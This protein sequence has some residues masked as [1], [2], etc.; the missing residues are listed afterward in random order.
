MKDPPK[1]PQSDRKLWLIMV[2]FIILALAL[3]W[4]N[5]S[6]TIQV[7]V[8]KGG[9]VLDF[10]DEGRFAIDQASARGFAQ[11][12]IK[13]APLL[14]A[15]DY[16]FL[17]A[18]SLTESESTSWQ[19]KGCETG[20]CSLAT[21]YDYTD[22]GTL[23]IVINMSSGEVI[24]FW[25]NPD[26][27]P[28][29]SP[30][31]LP[32][33]ISIAA[34][35]NEVRSVLGD[36]RQVESMMAPMST[37]LDDN[38]CSENWCVDLTFKS[39]DGSGKIFHVV[40]DLELGIVARTFYTRGRPER[41]HQEISQRE[42]NFEDGCHEEYE[43]EICWEMTAHDG[44]NF[45]DASY[46]G[47][48]IFTSAKIGQVEVF[49]PSW[50]GGYRDEI[51][52]G[53]SVRPY[54][55][56]QVDDLEEGFEV[57][58]LF[59]EFLSWPNCICCYRY[60]QKMRFFADGSFEA[61]FV[62]HGP[63][64]DD[65]SIYRPFWRINLAGESAESGAINFWD[66]REWLEAEKELELPLFERLG[67]GGEILY[68]FRQEGGYRW[69]P[70]LT[71][72]SGQDG[73]RIFVLAYNET[74]GD[75][76]ISTGPAN[77]LWPP[78]QW[79]DGEPLLTDNPVLWYIPSLNTH[80]GEPW[81]CMPDPEPDYSPCN[82]V[83]RAE[84]MVQ[85]KNAASTP[86]PPSEP[87]P[88]ATPSVKAGSPMS[89][90]LEPTAR[91]ALRRTPRPIAG[92]DAGSIILNSGCGSC[93]VIGSLGEI[94]KVGP[95]L[96]NIGIE[97]GN[98]VPGQSAEEFIRESILNP[99]AVIAADCPNGP[100]LDNIMPADYR[101]RL[102]GLQSQALVDFLLIQQRDPVSSEVTP[103]SSNQA[104]LVEEK[105]ATPEEPA[106]GVGSKLIATSITIGL[107]AL[108]LFLSL[109]IIALLLLLIFG[110]KDSSEKG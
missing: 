42:P 1:A 55:G 100:C 21:Y 50:P 58:Q 62:S 101:K 27:R 38:S 98:R 79:L 97:A 53:A 106:V 43:W 28:G 63:G 36:I 39:P 25:R 37:W 68:T 52:Q 82:A 75:G 90:A 104:S 6:R 60:E 95:D 110:A 31:S 85:V 47:Q 87:L 16:G 103:E 3:I 94:G 51:G 5:S 76:P 48:S 93:H 7:A 77:S 46:Q 49:Y 9:P 22:G 29:A 83:L 30:N 71:D 54:Y 2:L 78:R 88:P 57:S 107:I 35:D 96:S 8:S 26:S 109:V 41:E 81:W 34:D 10:F 4:G 108:I 24:D 67:P 32:R 102:S 40:V 69:I 80:H 56:T 45:Y 44:L 20:K 13:T 59:T 89:P 84:K 74:E 66:A 65:L 14:K 15:G 70:E 86:T 33:A 11:S 23:E 18:F 19:R 91:P 72:P 99:S 12:D 92:D 105:E 64:C 17:Y 61:G 73:G